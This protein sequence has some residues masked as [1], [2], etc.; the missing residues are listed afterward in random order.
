[1]LAGRT[2]VSGIGIGAEVAASGKLV[3]MATGGAGFGV[4]SS[5]L[6]AQATSRHNNGISCIIRLI[7]DAIVCNFGVA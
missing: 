2:A 1:V 5:T 4:V 3:T 7:T 6:S